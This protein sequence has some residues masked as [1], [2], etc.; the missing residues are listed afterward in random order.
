MVD[1]TDLK[2]VDCNMSCGFKSH[3]PHPKFSL[4]LQSLCDLK[5][6]FAVAARLC[7]K[8]APAKLCFKIFPMQLRGFEASLAWLDLKVPVDAVLLV[9]QHGLPCL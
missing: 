2:S 1:A 6:V 4:E 9:K 7:L 5:F 8:K 3:R